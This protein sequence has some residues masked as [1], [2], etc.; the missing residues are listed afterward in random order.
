MAYESIPV[1]IVGGGLVGLSAALFL[2]KHEIPYVLAERRGGTS[3]HPGARGFNVRTMELFRELGLEEAI[4]EAG[5]ALTDSTDIYTA[6][7]LS[8]AD[9]DLAANH[10]PEGARLMT[11]HFAKLADV[12]PTSGNLCTQDAVE[13]ILLEAARRQGGDLRFHTELKFFV[14]D[15]S[16]VTAILENR[17]TGEQQTIRAEY[18]IA[19]DGAKSQI[20]RALG[21]PM[22]GRGSRGHYIHI[23]FQADLSEIVRGK[24]FSIC[25]I[26]H[27]EARGM[28]VAV[29]NSDRWCFRVSCDPAAGQTPEDY[30]PERCRVL[31]AKALG[32]PG[33]DI[34]ILSVL[35]W[36]VAEW[37]AERF[38]DG[39]IFV[40]GDAAHVMPLSGGFGANTGVQDVHNLAWKLAAVLDGPA[41]SALLDTYQEERHPVAEYTVKQAGLIADTGMLSSGAETPAGHLVATL[42]YR[43]ASKAVIEQD[44]GRVTPDGELALDGRPGTRAPHAWV[45]V[46][47]ERRSTLDLFGRNFVLLAGPE[48][49]AW[50]GAAECASERLG[51]VINVYL[52]GPDH[53]LVD[54]DD[55]CLDAYRLTSDGAVLVRPDGF[56]AWRAERYS[57][58]AERNLASAL[59]QILCCTAAVQR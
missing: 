59:E 50:D 39:R 38:R 23:Y 3:I 48:G 21:I 18:M 49:V 27:P 8:V 32:I 35:P 51:I 46:Y 52:V 4:R 1:L 2:G 37:V 34:R 6:E 25:N 31:V 53:D 12:S 14:Q 40:A 47:R 24:E 41:G 54:R 55:R 7:T 22:T 58:D 45:E 42:G 33:L 15:D 56:V 43:Y 26:T 17:A 16:G 44:N 30:P 9:L 11:G 13:P 19:A 57:R 29:N 28:L 5:A 10:V 20:R 36:E